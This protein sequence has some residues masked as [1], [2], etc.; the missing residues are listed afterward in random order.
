[1]QAFFRYENLKKTSFLLFQ[2]THGSFSSFLLT[3]VDNLY[4]FCKGSPRNSKLKKSF[5]FV[6]NIK[7]INLL[8]MNQ[9]FR[10]ATYCTIVYLDACAF[11]ISIN[12]LALALHT[13]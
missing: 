12:H 13:K 10:H 3:G 9:R 7:N 2:N 1:M 6:K 11:Q 8:K 5:V 4:I